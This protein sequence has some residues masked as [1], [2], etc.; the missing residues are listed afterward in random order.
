MDMYTSTY[1]MYIFVS[2][3]AALFHNLGHARSLALERRKCTCVACDQWPL[4]RRRTSRQEGGRFGKTGFWGDLRVALRRARCFANA[5]SMHKGT[6]A[7]HVSKD[8]SSLKL[9]CNFFSDGTAVTDLVHPAQ[10]FGTSPTLARRPHL[11]D[12]S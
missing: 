12:A 5:Y 11:Y 10:I 4:A 3:L 2:R 9:H 8:P 7:T 1:N 6:P